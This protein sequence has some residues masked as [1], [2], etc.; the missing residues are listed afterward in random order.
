M[1]TSSPKKKLVTVLRPWLVYKRQDCGESV[2]GED[3]NVGRREGGKNESLA[4]S[5]S[6]HIRGGT[7]LSRRTARG[8]EKGKGRN[9]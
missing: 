6:V 1:G 8:E 9:L 5:G 3:T 2:A 7:A 4:C